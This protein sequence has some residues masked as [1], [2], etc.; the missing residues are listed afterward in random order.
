MFLTKNVDLLPDYDSGAVAL[1]NTYWHDG[2][3]QDKWK[4]AAANPSFTR[5]LKENRVNID[6]DDASS[7]PSPIAIE[8]LKKNRNK[9]NYYK[10]SSNPGAW[11]L[12]CE[13]M[14]E[15]QKTGGM[16][17]AFNKN[18]KDPRFLNW[19]RLS[20]NPCMATELIANPDKLNW[21]FMCRNP[22]TVELVRGELFKARKSCKITDSSLL[23]N[24]PAALGWILE[25]LKSD[26]YVI[27]WDYVFSNPSAIEIIKYV[28]K[29]YPEQI[30]WL[31]IYENPAAIDMIEE[32]LK[33]NV[34]DTLLRQLA[35]YN[36]WTDYSHH[37][38]KQSSKIMKESP[39]WQD[40]I[41]KLFDRTNKINRAQTDLKKYVNICEFETAQRMLFDAYHVRSSDAL[42]RE[43]R[44]NPRY[45][46][47]ILLVDAPI[48]EYIERKIRRN[49]FAHESEEIEYEIEGTFTIKELSDI[50]AYRTLKH[51]S[52]IQS[53]L[54]KL[55][56]PTN[57]W[58]PVGNLI[59]D[60]NWSAKAAKDLLGPSPLRAYKDLKNKR[61]AIAHLIGEKS[62]YA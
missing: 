37:H 12:I 23:A 50:N 51:F 34:S 48:H 25:K 39:S 9:I 60:M 61:N 30:N 36:F 3:K 19:E 46:K 5:Q 52:F 59:T 15:E 27:N 33:T 4:G 18:K 47:K 17:R 22:S 56:N 16:S 41:K 49:N 57:L 6:W 26:P 42:I 28:Y 35:R 29:H 11:E 55:C 1:F 7:N 40:D 44:R 14:I 53:K 2:F 20:E 32:H 38:F 8:M 45:A 13:K 21:Y 24:N 54:A 10:L 43:M 31:A 58:D 62:I